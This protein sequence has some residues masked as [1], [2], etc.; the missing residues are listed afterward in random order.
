MGNFSYQN[1]NPTNC[2]GGGTD[3]TDRKGIILDT[4]SPNTSYSQQ[5]VVA[6]NILVGTGVEQSRY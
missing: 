6:N 1:V 2:N 3:D 4:I 5:I